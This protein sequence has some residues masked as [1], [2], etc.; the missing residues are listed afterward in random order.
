MQI[1]Q[2][3][4]TIKIDASAPRGFNPLSRK[5]ALIC[6]RERMSLIQQNYKMRQAFD[7]KL[8]ESIILILC[9]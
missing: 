3:L 7:S 2:L 4:R 8:I 5:L 9:F 1:I 6:V